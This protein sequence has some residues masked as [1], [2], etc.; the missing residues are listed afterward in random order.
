MAAKEVRQRIW[1]LIA[2]CAVVIFFWFSFHQNGLTL[3]YFAKD[4]TRL[5]IGS[6]GLSAEI[7]QSMNPFFVVFLTPLVL[8]FFGMMRAGAKSLRRPPRSRSEWESPP[9]P[10]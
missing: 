5:S 6:L 3:T 10:T 7:F 9:S 4:Y 2:V 8:A 1:A